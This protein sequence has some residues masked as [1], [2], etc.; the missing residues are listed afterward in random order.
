MIGST[1]KTLVIVKPAAYRRPESGEMWRSHRSDVAKP[2]ART[3]AG[4]KVAN[5]LVS[6]PVNACLWIVFEETQ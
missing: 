6:V 1:M 3:V 2:L 5:P 4:A